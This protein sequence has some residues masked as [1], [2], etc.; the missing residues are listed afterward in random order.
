MEGDYL[1]LDFELKEMVEGKFQN[2]DRYTH[3]QHKK[4]G[5]L[6]LYDYCWLQ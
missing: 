3:T 5:F 1:L 2:F 6:K 4:E